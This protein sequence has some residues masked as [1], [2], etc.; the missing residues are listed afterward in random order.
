MWNDPL[1]PLQA[2]RGGFHRVTK[3]ITCLVLQPI[4]LPCLQN[5]PCWVPSVLLVPPFTHAVQAAR[6]AKSPQVQAVPSLIGSSGLM[7]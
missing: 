4:N 7:A 5:I 1:P 2:Q 3:V 6:W